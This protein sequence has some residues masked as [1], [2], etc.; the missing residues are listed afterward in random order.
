LKTL[1]E[2]RK[3]TGLSRRQI[4]ELESDKANIAPKPA[5]HNKYGYL[6]Y[7]D[8]EI[9]NL[10]QLS[11]YKALDCD[12]KDIKD[13]VNASP[14]DRAN[15]MGEV[16]EDLENKMDN[17]RKMIKIAKLEKQMCIS[18][19]SM[20]FGIEYFDNL[21]FDDASSLF[22]E[23]ADEACI[24][25]DADMMWEDTLSAEDEMQFF[26]IISNILKMCDNNLS[27]DADE[28]QHQVLLLHSIASK[29]I[30]PSMLMF[31]WYI[32]MFDP[33]GELAYEINQEY[34]EGKAE[35][36]YKSLKHYC[37]EHAE[38]EVDEEYENCL[39]KLVDLGCQKHAFD[40]SVVQV[41]VD[42]LFEY[43]RQIP[44]IT[45]C[46]RL[47]LFRSMGT[48]FGNDGYIEAI[49]CGRY[50]KVFKYISKAIKFY[51]RDALETMR[52]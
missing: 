4:Q 18:Y 47:F 28:V 2:V 36:L 35:Y 48:L 22:A 15:Q 50:R 39:A 43:Y 49:Q 9:K 34:G 37:G 11:F 8:D 13:I 38:N 51:C 29:E 3:I 10:W 33:D 5:E 44:S 30:S 40:S 19:S 1:S 24:Y 23:I 6:L 27:Y 32:L 7:N 46:G 52:G 25:E 41:A 45:E 21:S 20:R 26:H 14:E 17:F 42:E 31:S 16:V 12:R